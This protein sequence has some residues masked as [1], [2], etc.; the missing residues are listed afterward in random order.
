MKT[1]FFSLP[2]NE[3]LTDLLVQQEK[4]EKGSLEIRQFPDGE[5][6]VRILSDVKDTKVVLVCTLHQPDVK[7]LPLYFLAKTAKELGAHN[8]CLIAPY[9]AYMRQD[10][11][12]YPGEAISSSCFAHLISSFVDAIITVDPHLHRRR[13]LSEIYTVPSKVAH[14]A[15]H[16]STWI[17]NNIDK[18]ILIGPD[19]ES[20]QWVAEVARNSGTPYLILTKVRYGD[21]DVQVSIP[22]VSKYKEHTP[23]LVDDIISTGRTMIETIGHLKNAG[24]KPPICIGVHAVFSGNTYQEIKNSGAKEV[25][26]CNTIPHESNRIDIHDL[27]IF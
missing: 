25:I 18:P 17:K 4:A 19:N 3:K 1:I 26:T 15:N 6:Y 20:E 27:L 12:F 14:A 24:M 8:I 9:L 13:S 21:R 11:A 10:K 16:I 23:V 5:T 7:L 22:D 2:G